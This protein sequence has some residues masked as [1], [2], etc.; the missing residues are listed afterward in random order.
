MAVIEGRPKILLPVDSVRQDPQLSKDK[1][2]RNFVLE[3]LKAEH[4]HA[5]DSLATVLKNG[6]VIVRISDLKER[7]PMKVDF[8][9]EFSKSNPKVLEKFK[10]ELRRTAKSKSE[11]PHLKTK[12]KIL[13]KDERMKILASIKVGN[14]GAHNFHKISFD[15]LIHIFG[16]RLSNPYSEREINEGRK[17]IDIVFDNSGKKGFFHSLDRLY[18]I[19]CP[20]IFA[21][22]KNYGKEIGNPEVDQ[23]QNRFNSIRGRFGLL[24]CRSIRDRKLLVKRC[25]DAYNDNKSYIIV[26]EDAD[27]EQLLNFKEQGDENGIDNFMQKKLDLIIM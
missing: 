2:Y 12:R 5:G 25:K 15:N 16:S 7:Y 18:H 27:V 17:R 13:S 9:Y 10:S 14:D 23:L 26:L 8:L 1:Y 24:L 22:C 19:Q 4:E 20:K 21:E 3:F 11:Q 6:R